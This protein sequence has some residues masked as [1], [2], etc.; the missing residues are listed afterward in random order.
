MF[1]ESASQFASSFTKET[2]LSQT[3]LED[4]KKIIDSEILKKKK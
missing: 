3:E 2:N 4:L 1:P